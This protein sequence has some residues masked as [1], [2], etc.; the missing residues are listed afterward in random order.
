MDDTFVIQ[1]EEHIQIFLEHIN[2]VDYA[3]K[4]TVESNQQD[5]AIPFLDTIVLA[6]GL[7]ILAKVKN[8]GVFMML[9]MSITTIVLKRLNFSCPTNRKI[10]ASMR[11]EKKN[12]E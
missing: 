10:D 2:K 12:S 5:G 6:Y 7:Y 8:I 11:K 1:Q 3:I 9:S 4:F